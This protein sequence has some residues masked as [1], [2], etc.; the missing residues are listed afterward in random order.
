MINTLTFTT[1]QVTDTPGV[2]DAD[3]TK[4][5]RH[6]DKILKYLRQAP[7]INAIIIMVAEGR[8]DERVYRDMRALMKEFNTLPCAKVMVFR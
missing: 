8:K 7:W 1:Q 2:P 4:S 5:L 3:R 6:Y